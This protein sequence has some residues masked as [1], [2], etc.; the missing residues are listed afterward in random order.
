ME[1]F[2]KK[3]EETLIVTGSMKAVIYSLLEAAETSA[4]LSNGQENG[5]PVN[6]II[7]HTTILNNTPYRMRKVAGISEPMQGS[8]VIK[9]G[10]AIPSLLQGASVDETSGNKWKLDNHIKWGLRNLGMGTEAAVVYLMEDIDLLIVFYAGNPRSGISYAGCSFLGISPFLVGLDMNHNDPN[11]GWLIDEM[12][13]RNALNSR[14]SDDASLLKVV[15]PGHDVQVEF[16]PAMETTFRVG[17]TGN[18]NRF[19]VPR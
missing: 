7:I 8:M 18:W 10:S 19:R 3:K 17:F 4:H 14:Y 2:T 16:T 13:S 9:P 15:S 1:N 6:P 5:K 12:R 11:G